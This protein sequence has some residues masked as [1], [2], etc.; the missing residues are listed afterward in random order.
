[1]LLMDIFSYFA[2]TSFLYNIQLQVG[3][4]IEVQSD[5]VSITSACIRKMQLG[6]KKNHKKATQI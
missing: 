1:M 6:E 3:L 5:G 4:L 2:L